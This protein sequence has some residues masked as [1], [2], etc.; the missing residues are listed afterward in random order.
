RLSAAQQAHVPAGR[1]ALDREVEHRG[2]QAPILQFQADRRGGAVAN[3]DGGKIRHQENTL[4]A[5]GGIFGMS[6]R[7]ESSKN[8]RNRRENEASHG[9]SP[10]D[11]G[12]S[13]SS[14]A[15]LAQATGRRNGAARRQIMT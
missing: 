8:N 11:D 6:G 12:L 15:C 7:G 10:E 14:R 9:A 3:G 1:L 2:G 5:L 4:D 13:V